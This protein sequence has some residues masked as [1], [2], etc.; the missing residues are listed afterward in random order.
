MMHSRGFLK[1]LIPI[2]CLIPFIVGTVG[3]A[4]SGVM[5]TD[6]L[7]ASF[8]LYFT[9]H[10]FDAYNGCIE[11]ARWTAPLV[12]ATAI[13]CVLES[14]W[15][16]I[17][18]RL[19]CLFGDSVAVYSDEAVDI[20]FEKGTKAIYPGNS[21]KRFVK[22]HIILFSSDQQNLQFYEENKG[23][24][25]GKKVYIGLRELDTGLL[26][27]PEGVE[28]FDINSGIARELWKE[29]AIWRRGKQFFNIVILGES[30]LAERVLAYGLLLNLFS[31][32]QQVSYHIVSEKPRFQ[33]KH[34]EFILQ[35]H[36]EILYHTPSKEDVW[37]FIRQADIVIAADL[38]SADLVQT[39]A[40]NTAGHEL[41]YFSPDEWDAG[42]Y[43]TYGNAEPFGKN[44]NILTDENIRKQNLIREAVSLN[45]EYAKTYNGESWDK[46]SGF[47]KNSNISAA[48][49]KEV[50]AALS[51]TVPEKELAELEHIRWCRFHYLHYWKKGIPE[52]GKN[53]DEAKRIH[54]DLVPFD[55]LSEE[56]QAKDIAVVRAAGFD[57]RKQI[58]VLQGVS[59][60]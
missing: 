52:N 59:M 55:E 15:K 8:S 34:P 7:Y 46:L 12:T 1:K 40:A 47:T 2:V 3:Y 18:W 44:K 11:F 22:S 53:K 31:K 16:N 45:E 30:V 23:Q 24:L 42:F 5:L 13:L 14:V 41:Y 37:R 38:V 20:T 29:I 6:S 51:G 35:N 28:L 48:D 43:L 56:E 49:Y 27:E 4:Q 17:V 10:I 39:L 21:I 9:S 19:K 54:K 32:R 26:K 33:R 57:S 50:L 36:D 60:P 58:K 25:A